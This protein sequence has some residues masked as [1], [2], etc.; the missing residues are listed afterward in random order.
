MS[1]RHEEMR[2]MK[3]KDEGERKERLLRQNGESTTVMGLICALPSW[4][5]WFFLLSLFSPFFHAILEVD[6]T[7]P[8]DWHVG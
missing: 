8:N 7:T 2:E 1:M 6:I 4:S 5:L 3:R